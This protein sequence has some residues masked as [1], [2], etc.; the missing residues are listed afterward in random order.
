MRVLVAMSGGVDSS[1]AAALLLQQGCNVE[2]INLRLASGGCSSRDA[3]QNVCDRLQIPLRCIDVQAEF[4]REVIQ[5]FISE[6][7]QGRTPNPCVRCNHIIKFGLLM[8]YARKH[9]FDRL[10]TGH[11]AR[12]EHDDS[13]SQFLLKQAR[14]HSKDQ[15]YFLYRLS[16]EQMQMLLFPVGD[17]SKKEVRA[18]AHT[19]QLP[20]AESPESQE[21]CFIE[22]HNYRLYLKHHAPETLV[23]GNLIL[24]DGTIVG[25]HEGIAFFTV[26]QRRKLGVAAGERL[27]VLKIEPDTHAV[28]LGKKAELEKKEL[29]VAQTH[30]IY[31]KRRESSREVMVKIRYRSPFVPAH[32]Y[33]LDPDRTRVI[34]KQPVSGICPGQAAVF[35][36]GDVVVGGG[37]IE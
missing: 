24:S 23:P 27:Y 30:F 37:I 32:L 15:S 26:G 11:Y 7:Q 36:D 33:P 28:V 18:Y 35:Y 20:S 9:A 12:I 13:Q 21:I 25:H 10:A 16:Q 5:N 29:T 31:Q 34:F 17:L 14:D 6:Y 19:L 3:A 1:V 2:G 22:H 4:S 8:D